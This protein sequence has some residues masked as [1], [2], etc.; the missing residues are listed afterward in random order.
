MRPI[1]TATRALLASVVLAASVAGCQIADEPQETGEIVI[2]A[3]LELS[4]AAAAAGQAYQRALELKVEQVNQS[5]VLGGRTLKLEV[6]DNRS[7]PNESLRNINDFTAN[8]AVQA[9]IMGSCGECAVGAAK[10]VNEK[11]VPTIALAAS[12]EVANPVAERRYLFKLAPNASDNAA[13]L[14]AE[15]K[16]QRISKVSLLYTD[17][18]YGHEGKQAMEG[19]LQ[20]AKIKLDRS[21]H[22]KVTDNDVSNVV[23]DLVARKPGALV[24]WAT[25]EQANL[26]S[27]AARD[28]AFNGKLFFDAGAAGGL[29]L[30]TKVAKQTNGATMVFTQTMVIDDVIATTPAKAARKQWFR[31]YTAR[32]GGYN[33]FSSFA[34]DAVQLITEAVNKA[35]STSDKVNRNGIRDVL[36]T[37]QMEGLSGPIRMTPDNHSGLMPQA[38]TMLVAR[39]GRWRLAS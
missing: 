27:V 32:Y 17:D 35:G 5:G 1:R 29:F 21:E 23:G 2:A 14:V 34:A 9:I 15:L 30:G 22:V 31:D 20:K 28:A 10:T 26:A 38:L 7:D 18:G 3:D 25:A 37:S 36:E 13:A 33:G 8:P 6:K 16:H 11:R 12:D 19:E 4:G 39:N 24:I